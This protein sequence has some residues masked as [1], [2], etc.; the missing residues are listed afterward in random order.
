MT[1]ISY[2]YC[3]MAKVPE[4]FRPDRNLYHFFIE[5]DL[6]QPIPLWKQGTLYI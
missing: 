3:S 4:Y 1:G 6:M 2:G 5:M